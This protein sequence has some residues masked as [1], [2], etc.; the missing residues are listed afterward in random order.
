MG[1][2]LLI[3]F[4]VVPLVEIGVFI[5]VGG[6]IG[7][8]PTLL[9]IVATAILGAFMVRSQGMA[10]VRS[11]RAAMSRGEAPITQVFDGI[12]LLASGLLLLTPGCVTDA[13]GGVL[14]V[15]AFRRWL[16]ARLLRG[17]L[18]TGRG[19]ADVGPRPG[20]QVIDEDTDPED[21]GRP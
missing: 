13:L 8:I 3:A 7:T 6:A 18:D 4:I 2:Y 17:L 5:Q 15:P 1:L 12:C 10:T 9:V 21:A 20:F 19:R 14:L 11:A 16:R